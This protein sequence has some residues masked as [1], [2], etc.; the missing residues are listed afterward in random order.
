VPLSGDELALVPIVVGLVSSLTM[1]FLLW[2]LFRRPAAPEP[3]NAETRCAALRVVRTHGSDSLAF[4]KLRRDEH[5]LFTADRHAF[6]GYRVLRGMLLVS[7]DPVGPPAAF[8][9][10]VGAVIE[11]ADRHGL[12]VGGFMRRRPGTPNGLTEFL[13]VR[14]IEALRAHGARE[15]S[16]NFCAFGRWQRAP[17]HVGERLA[18]RAL[19]PLDGLFQIASLHSFN[20]KFATSWSPRWAA[21]DGWASLPR[22]AVAAL[23]AE[24]QLPRPAL[25]ARVAARPRV[26]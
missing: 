12:R 26:A 17:A 1:G 16:L 14:A 6:L 10:L 9:E 13:L 25:W 24:G 20:A 21:V 7:G 23:D 18:V 15:L 11:L 19:E 4:F 8:S 3:P 5:Y 22:A 2:E